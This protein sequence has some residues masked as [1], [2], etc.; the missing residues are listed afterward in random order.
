MMKFHSEAGLD[1]LVFEQFFRGKRGGVFVEV[2]AYDGEHGSR[3]LFF[4]RV[5]DWRGLCVEPLPQAFAALRA[6]R[7]CA[8][9]QV[10]VTDFDGE[11]E[12]VEVLDDASRS[13]GLEATLDAAVR[14]RARSG[15]ANVARRVV[16]VRTLGTL[17]ERHGLYDVDYC[18][19]D[20]GGAEVGV[21]A[22]LDLSRFAV[23]VLTVATHG[24]DAQISELLT[25]RGYEP[26]TKLGG[27]LVFRRRDVQRLAHTTVICAVWHGDPDRAR[28]LRGHA[29]NLSRQ[30]VPVQSIYVFDGAD[31]PA[32]STPG[33]KVVVHENLTIYQAWNVALALVDT[34]FVMN[35]NLDDR[36]APNAVETLESALAAEG[37][38]LAGADWKVCYSQDE[39]D[40]VE[41]CYPVARLPFV[42]GWP[43]L[44]GV[45]TRLGS[46]TGERGTFGPA[47][48]W[49]LDAHIGAPR[50]PWRLPEGTL[51]KSAADTGWWRIVNGHLRKRMIRLP[52]VIGNYYSHPSTQA[53]FRGPSDELRLMSELGVSLT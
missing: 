9:E 23:K 33:R 41:P 27:H 21:L 37:A 6:R 30:T 42:P 50:Y 13:S 34:P 18:S 51:I 49:R 3:S 44:P 10:C 46:G 48:I 31:A 36:L 45:T 14:E 38:A 26:F 47:V 2:G 29:E 20:A 17:L 28:L 12:F 5:L 32:E 24:R 19:I 22:A 53:E 8:C 25:A 4:E 1:Q 11:A 16:P 43:P 7:R 52:M 40:A 39:T 35:L 15:P